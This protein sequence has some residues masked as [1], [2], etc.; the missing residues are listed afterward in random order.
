[1]QTHLT[2]EPWR[3]HRHFIGIVL[4]ALVGFCVSIFGWCAVSL[5]E[6]RMAEVEFLSR[7]KGH[8]LILQNGIDRIYQSD[9]AKKG[10]RVGREVGVGFDL[11]YWAQRDRNVS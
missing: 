8:G 10:A 3:Q 4:A 2:L 1:M 9:C 11:P 6:A 7:T 5:R